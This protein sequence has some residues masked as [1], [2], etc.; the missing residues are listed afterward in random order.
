MEGSSGTT[1]TGAE[2]PVEE[3]RPVGTKLVVNRR[4]VTGT[5]GHDWILPEPR[6]NGDLFATR[7]EVRKGKRRS[8]AAGARRSRAIHGRSGA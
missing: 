7:A 6:S 5:T 3:L 8:R 1:S 2:M 4:N